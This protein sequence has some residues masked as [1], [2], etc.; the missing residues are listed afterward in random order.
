V[1]V[2]EGGRPIGHVML[3]QRCTC[4]QVVMA[5]AFDAEGQ[6]KFTRIDNPCNPLDH[7]S[8]DHCGWYEHNWPVM[9][10]QAP[11]AEPVAHITHRQHCNSCCYPTWLG[12]R[13]MPQGAAPDEQKL[14]V[15][16][17]HARWWRTEQEEQSSGNSGAH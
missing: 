14:L 15:A 13:Q 10:T 17:L 3:Y 16:M 7:F 12:I 9:W 11:E 5:E 6:S 2:S 4:S 8:G 1:D